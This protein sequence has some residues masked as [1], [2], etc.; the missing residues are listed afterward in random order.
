[1]EERR[2]A[3]LIG[4]SNYSDPE[5]SKLL[6][7]ADDTA[8]LARVLENPHICGFHV[9]ILHDETETKLRREIE[10]FLL[11]DKQR[12]DLLLLYFS[13]HGITDLE[14]QL[15]FAAADTELDHHQV[16]Q[17]SAISAKFVNEL[18]SQSR[19]RRIILLLDCCHSG[20][21]KEGMLAKGGE[22][23]GAIEQLQGQGRVVL[24][25]SNALQ[26]SFEGDVVHGGGTRS[27]FTHLLAQGLETGDADQDGDGRYS[28]DD[29]Y[30]YVC[31]RMRDQR[32]TQQPMKMAFVEGDIFLG[33]NPSPKAS[34]LPVDVLEDLRHPRNEIRLS[35]VDQLGKLLLGSHRGRALAASR[36]LSQLEETDDSQRVRRA[37][38]ECLEQF[39]KA[40]AERQ[41]REKAAA[42]EQQRIAREKVEAERLERERAEAAERERKAREQEEAE[43]QAREKAETERQAREKAA[44]EEQQRIARETAE[45]ERH[46]RERAKAA[47]R[48]RK[49]REQTDAERQQRGKVAD[50]QQARLERNEAE[51]ARRDAEAQRALE[52][53]EQIRRKVNQERKPPWTKW[54]AAKLVAFGFICVALWYGV[55]WLSTAPVH[56]APVLTL[57]TQ[58]VVWSLSWSPDGARLATAT[59]KH[60]EVWDARIGEKLLTLTLES[61]EQFHSVAWSPDGKRIATGSFD[62]SSKDIHN[63]GHW[64]LWDA[65]TG[66]NLVTVNVSSWQSVIVAWSPDGKRLATASA[67]GGPTVW[68]PDKAVSLLS[69]NGPGVWGLAWSPEGKRLA[70][71]GDDFIKVWDADS[72][73]ELLSITTN[74]LTQ[75]LV[76]GPDGDR[77]LGGTLYL[78]DFNENSIT[79]YLL[80]Y[81][82]QDRPTAVEWDA[83][84]GRTLLT[85]R[86]H[87]NSNQVAWSP[88]GHRI[89]IGS[90]GHAS[91][92]DA[93]TGNQ[94]MAFGGGQDKDITSVAWSPGG[95]WLATGAQ[96]NGG[97]NGEAEVWNTKTWRR[98]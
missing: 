11:R 26:Y 67:G 18:M 53:E 62:L 37:A 22:G 13:G 43:R 45:A 93:K 7:P 39:Q 91:L 80:Y 82:Q 70:T 96:L 1:M 42:E 5:L 87:T 31:D 59:D 38:K 47:E 14:G 90:D 25:A 23:A 50:V 94:L 15:Y 97:S 61:G 74:T 10:K 12:D 77:L 89:A 83:K 28:I 75:S 17:S 49:A 33:N 48:E 20:A 4:N 24:T 32:Q 95:N 85:L 86:G 19:S 9:Q 21:F 6:A 8:D 34:Q 63:A 36:E 29:L 68:D 65:G 52:N 54:L 60:I 88:D 84:T 55:H 35:A 51:E 76:W 57:D 98:P 16:L 3:L 2:F 40:E 78:S 92:W 66:K 27:I 73:K 46:E 41:A 71:S 58:D 56:A 72:G 44:A 30:S 64:A 69:T 81:I 79:L